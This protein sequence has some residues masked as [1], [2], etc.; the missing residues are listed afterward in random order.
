MSPK[1]IF[2]VT[3]HVFVPHAW[4]RNSLSREYTLSK[5]FQQI[6]NLSTVAYSKYEKILLII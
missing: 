6:N 1:T 3:N 5:Q 2:D 4:N